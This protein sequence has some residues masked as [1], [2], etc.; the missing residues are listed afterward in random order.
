M[1]SDTGEA[2]RA[3]EGVTVVMR[4]IR[5]SR[6]V[7]SGVQKRIVCCRGHVCACVRVV[8]CVGASPYEEL[9]YSNSTGN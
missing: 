3:C 7:G 1:E 5:V 9:R 4:R 6:E 2:G 8:P